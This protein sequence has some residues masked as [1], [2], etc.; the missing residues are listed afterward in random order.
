MGLPGK[1]F[2]PRDVTFIHS[3]NAEIFGDVVQVEV[4][5]F[6]VAPSETPTNIYGESDPTVGKMFYPGIDITARVRRNDIQT[7][8]DDFGPKRS[9]VVVFAFREKMLK[10]INFFPQVG[11]IIEFN[12]RYHEVDNVVQEQFL[13][14]VPDKSLSIVCNTHYSRLSKISLVERQT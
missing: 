12:F 1:F 8:Y 6:K 3:I 11:D 9:Q 10:E 4:K 13:G 14:G 7:N 5:V 2:G